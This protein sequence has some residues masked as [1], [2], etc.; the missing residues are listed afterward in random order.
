[1]E[2]CRKRGDVDLAAVAE[3][4]DIS[5]SFQ[6]VPRNSTSAPQARAI[7][8]AVPLVHPSYP[9]IILVAEE[10]PVPITLKVEVQAYVPR[11]FSSRNAPAIFGR[12]NSSLTAKT[13]QN[14]FTHLK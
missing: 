5:R 1:M 13:N 10:H 2:S 3:R 8:R 4:R 14:T 12:Q 9:K 7:N 11:S 6:R